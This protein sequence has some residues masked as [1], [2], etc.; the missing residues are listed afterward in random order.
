MRVNICF[1]DCSTLLLNFPGLILNIGNDK[2]LPYR[3][4]FQ[5]S[6]LKLDFCNFVSILR[7]YSI[8]EQDFWMSSEEWMECETW[9]SI[10]LC[11]RSIDTIW[12]KYW[13]YLLSTDTDMIFPLE[14]TVL[15]LVLMVLALVLTVLELVLTILVLA[16]LVNLKLQGIWVL[17]GSYPCT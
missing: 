16:P 7:Y 11:K 8:F 10:N 15:A 13:L 6:H 5:V 9:I 2:C 12:H 4:P 3:E 14:L 17:F 1:L